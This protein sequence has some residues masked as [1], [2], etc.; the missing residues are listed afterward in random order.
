MKSLKIDTFSLLVTA[1]T[2]MS[3]SALEKE[4][5]RLRYSLPFRPLSTLKGPFTLKKILVERIPNAWA[6]RYG[7]IDDICLCLKVDHYLHR[8][9]ENLVTKAVPRSATGPDFKK[10]FIGSGGH[11]GEITEA[12]FRIIPL[13]PRQYRLKIVWSHPGQKNI[14]LKKFWGS[15]VAPVKVIDKT[16]ALL[17]QLEGLLEIVEGEKKVISSLT[18]ETKG[19]ITNLT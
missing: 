13:P 8:T 15:G 9:H 16:S 1:K 12:T 14:F 18:R 3:L 7:E 19:K 4:L 10:I 5:N 2:D 11:Y 17:I 6:A